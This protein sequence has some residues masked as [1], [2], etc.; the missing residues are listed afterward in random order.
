MDIEDSSVAFN[1]KASNIE[2][3]LSQILPLM[4][5]YKPGQYHRDQ[6]FEP[7]LEEEEND[8]INNNQAVAVV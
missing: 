3:N 2:W 4:P 8:L 1:T 7:L 6:S 5:K